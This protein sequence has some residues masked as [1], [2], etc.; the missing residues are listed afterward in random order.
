MTQ[1]NEIGEPTSETET[2]NRGN[3]PRKSLKKTEEPPELNEEE[4]EHPAS[5]EIGNQNKT[6]T[7]GKPDS[8]QRATTLLREPQMQMSQRRN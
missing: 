1:N 8:S 6:E 3:T 7:Q 4:K 5:K 2:I